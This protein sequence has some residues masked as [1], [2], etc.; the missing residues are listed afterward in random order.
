MTNA[1]RSAEAERG[2]R[3]GEADAYGRRLAALVVT[4][5]RTAAAIELMRFDL[6][7]GEGMGP[8]ESDPVAEAEHAVMV[9]RA[10]ARLEETERAL[11][12]ATDELTQI[13]AALQ[14]VGR[15]G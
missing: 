11:Q 9:R 14:E 12:T 2:G 6:R 3:G 10:Q 5:A 13:F 4:V 15:R 8:G 7:I 1:D